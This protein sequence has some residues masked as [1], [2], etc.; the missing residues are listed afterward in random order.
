[1]MEDLNSWVTTAASW[2]TLISFGAKLARKLLPKIIESFKIWR[3][4]RQKK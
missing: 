3:T 2:I 4:Y 1:M